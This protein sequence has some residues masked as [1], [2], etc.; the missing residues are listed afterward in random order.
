MIHHDSTV[1]RGKV[2]LAVRDYGGD[3]IPMVLLHGGGRNLCDWAASAQ[4]LVAHHR[5]VALDFR[6]HGSSTPCDDV[7]SFAE[8]LDDVAAV[9]AYFALDNPFLVGHS[10]GGM[11]A[12]LYGARHHTCRGVVNV[13]GVGVSLPTVFPVSDPEVARQRI[14]DVIE[15][16]ASAVVPTSAGTAALLNRAAVDQRLA[17][18]RAQAEQRGQDWSIVGPGA[19]RSFFRTPDGRYQENPSAVAQAALAAAVLDV[20]IFAMTRSVRC[21]LLFI[22]AT[23]RAGIG[24]NGDQLSEVMDIWR[25]GVQLEFEQITHERPNVRWSGL[26]GDHMLVLHAAEPLTDSVLRFTGAMR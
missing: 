5:V 9:I 6:S 21:P 15:A 19:E 20:D 22:G 11:V 7:W 1:P 23:G 13:D 14:R 26:A 8:A 4:R 2:A 18:L 16:M 24:T 25:G 3:G 10:L 17:A 12:T